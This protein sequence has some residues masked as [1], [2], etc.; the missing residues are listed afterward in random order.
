MY[1][2]IRCISI[3]C[4]IKEAIISLNR[5][6][7]KNLF[8]IISGNYRINTKI[9]RIYRESF[10]IFK[11]K[12][13]DGGILN[14]QQNETFMK[15]LVFKTRSFKILLNLNEIIYFKLWQTKTKLHTFNSNF[16]I[17]YNIK[18]LILK[19]PQDSFIQIHR[20]CIVNIKHV[21]KY[22]IST[23]SY[24]VTD[25]GEKLSISRNFKHSFA[26]KINQFH[27]PI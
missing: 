21:N 15:K 12:L 26:T 16:I 6:R 22:M 25:T 18:E 20:S 9:I 11:N 24:L 14:Y 2:K 7:T 19:L 1:Q 5:K 17:N 13:M 10:P 3:F 8:V 23:D 27:Y 4:E